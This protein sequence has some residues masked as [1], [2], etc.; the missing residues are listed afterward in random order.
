M[1]RGNAYLWAGGA[2]VVV[3]LG[4]AFAALRHMRRHDHP[5]LSL[6]V[7]RHQTYMVAIGIA[8]P[9]VRLPI[10]ALLFAVPILL[11]VC[12][13]FSAFWSGMALFAHAG[14]DL[15]CKLV[16]TRTLRRFGYRKT[17]M[18]ALPV[19]ALGMCGAALIGSHTPFGAITLLMF[20]SG[21]ARSFVMTGVNTLSFAEVAPEEASSAV[22][23]AQVVMQVA[24][25]LAVSLAVLLIQASG[26][27]RSGAI[28]RI[29]TG[30]VQLALLIMGAIGFLALPW[31]WRLPHDAGHQLTRRAA[32]Q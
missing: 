1:S 16:M 32:A 7:F 30:D 17:L 22:T 14:G 25:A 12:L 9:F 5:I 20:V 13:G 27:L 21:C 18:T 2:V 10:G 23:V 15:M 31:L 24:A 28:A 26:Y 3:G 8:L 4:I 6:A 19:M 29:A 11:Q